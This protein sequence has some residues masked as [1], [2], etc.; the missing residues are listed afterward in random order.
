MHELDGN[1]ELAKA[2]RELPYE[3]GL[4]KW[5]EQSLGPRGPIYNNFSVTALC[6]ELV[7][8]RAEAVQWL[9]KAYAA[10]DS[11]LL[12]LICNPEW[13]NARKDQRVLSI[14]R[15]MGLEEY[16]RK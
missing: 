2:F 4:M 5:V 15:R 7:G 6:F 16:V 3:Q 14:I 13:A 12:E 1:P 9:E 10:H 8:K 11:S